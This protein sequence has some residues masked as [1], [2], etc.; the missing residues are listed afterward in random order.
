MRGGVRGRGSNPPTYSI[1]LF[2]IIFVVNKAG[3]KFNF[4]LMKYPTRLY[5]IRLQSGMEILDV[6]KIIKS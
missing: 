3:I 1:M 2:F 4:Y 5:F 6:E